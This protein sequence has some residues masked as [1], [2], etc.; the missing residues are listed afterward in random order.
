[1]EPY[2]LKP[3]EVELVRFIYNP[4]SGRRDN[5]FKA[6]TYIAG[7]KRLFPN[8]ELTAVATEAV[9]HATELA[10]NFVSLVKIT[11]KSANAVLV[12][13]GGDGTVSE[14]ANGIIGSEI[15]LL[16]LPGGTGNDF[17]RSLYQKVP[18]ENDR[19]TVDR[20]IKEF[21]QSRARGFRVFSIDALKI[22]SPSVESVTKDKYS[23]FTRYSLN[24]LSAG[25]DSVIGTT[26][27]RIHQRFPWVGAMSYIFAT[28][29]HL[30]HIPRFEMDL[31]ADLKE[32]DNFDFSGLYSICVMSNARFYGGGFQANPRGSL[33]DGKIDVLLAKELN[34]LEVLKLIGKFRAGEEIPK[35]YA[36]SFQSGTLNL[37]A[38]DNSEL[39][40]NV[41]GEVF[42]A[43]QIKVSVCPQVLQVVVPILD[44]GH[45]A[46]EK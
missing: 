13:S 41:D 5:T 46:F 44:G 6:D 42:T 3:T 14:T 7:L 23:D 8:A 25:F 24:V 12:V 32:G 18:G 1:M 17:T 2:L 20:V 36:E 38:W 22:E 40:F 43:Q 30:V 35:Q 28:V 21:A 10:E 15:P 31:K 39:V 45:P 4:V 16:V 11:E 9:G 26:A 27:Q 37:K 19:R 33:T 34:Q 29:R